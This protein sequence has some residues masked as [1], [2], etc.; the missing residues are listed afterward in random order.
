MNRKIILSVLLLSTMILAACGGAQPSA[1]PT[2]AAAQPTTAAVAQPTTA[3]APPATAPA[4][5]QPPAAGTPQKGGEMIVAYKDDLA[6]LDPA[7]GYDWTNWPAEKLVFDGLLDYD[8]GTTIEPRLAE[9]LPQVNADA[10]VYTFKLR[11]GV[12]FSNGRE[13]TADDVVYTLTRV[14]DPKT[15]SP[16]AGFFTGIKGAQEFIDGKA[17]SVSGIKALDANTVEFT[18][19]APDVTFLNKMALNFA[20]IV[21]KEEVD[22][23]GEN[24]GHAPVGTGPYLLKE[25]KSGQELTFE[26]NPNYFMSDRPNLDKITIQVGVAP[27]VALLRLEKGDIQLMGDPP[28]GADWARISA[29][30]AWKDRLEKQPQVSTIYIAINTTAKPFDNVKVRQA[31]NYAIDKQHIIQLLNGR[32]TTTNQVLPPLM[33]GY[34][35]SYTGYDYNPD[36]AKALLAEAGF[37]DG[38]ETSIEC[39]SVDPQP[40]LCESFQQDLA[41]VGIKL[42]INTLAAPNVIDDAGNGKT[43]LTWSG[44]LGWIQDYPDP[45]DF[46]GPILGCGSNTPGGWNWSRYCNET[47]D[48]QSKDLLAITDRA[49]RL[50]AYG[51]FFKTLMDDAVWVPVYNGEYDIAHSEKLHGQPTLTHPEHLFSYETMW[52]E[53]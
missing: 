44:G 49:K 13:F 41:K 48:K 16:G 42:T 9:S 35:K 39:I 25:W 43:P 20:F 17:T 26:R 12:K 36:K 51:P 38:F 24:F 40:K 10:T 29:D 1:A 19:T 22:K 27:D 47:V 53:K 28:P 18:L 31:L 32:G 50:E 4:P 6:T 34:D 46:Y 8:S 5:T 21:P 3:A 52:I 30:P 33:P 37:P 2:T 15:A 11:K 14:L 23:A 7:I 45:D